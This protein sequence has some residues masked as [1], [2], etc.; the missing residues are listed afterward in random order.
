MESDKIMEER[1]KRRER[2]ERTEK[3]KQYC[4]RVIGTR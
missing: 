3:S 1:N 2:R 4:G